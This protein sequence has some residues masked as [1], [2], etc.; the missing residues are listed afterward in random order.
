[1]VSGRVSHQEHGIEKVHPIILPYSHYGIIQTISNSTKP[2]SILIGRGRWGNKGRHKKITTL[3]QDLSLPLPKHEEYRQIDNKKAKIMIKSKVIPH[4]RKWI[5]TEK[6]PA[7]PVRSP[8]SP[9]IIYNEMGARICG[10]RRGKREKTKSPITEQK[11]D[12]VQVLYYTIPKV[13]GGG[14]IVHEICGR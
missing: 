3:R 9:N 10:R 4:K 5:G 6:L 8:F 14:N 13:K 2:K 12:I 11:T 1:M 7:V